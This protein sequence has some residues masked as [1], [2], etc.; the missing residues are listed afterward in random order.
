MHRVFMKSFAV[1]GLLLASLSTA[2]AVTKCPKGSLPYT[3]LKGDSCM[4]LVRKFNFDNPPSVEKF[5][6]PISGFQCTKAKAGQM[7]CAPVA[8]NMTPITHPASSLLALAPFSRRDQISFFEE[9]S[10][11]Q[12]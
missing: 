3:L 4:T 1:S 8:E 9:I 5:N 10:D 6:K 7:I 12:P 11:D 2:F